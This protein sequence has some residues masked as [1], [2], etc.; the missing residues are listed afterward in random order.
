MTTKTERILK[1]LHVLAWI[2]FIGLFIKAGAILISYLISLENTEA[3]SNLYEGLNL[4]ELRENKVY[5]YSILLAFMIGILLLQAYITYI[6]IKILSKINLSNPFHSEVAL[7]IE[8]VSYLILI[9]WIVTVIANAHIQ[10]LQ[11]HTMTVGISS[12]SIDFI[13]LAGVIFVI[14]QIFKRGVEIQSEQEL[15]V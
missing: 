8:K 11:D 1:V 5:H 4:S 7:L 6:V 10:W 3:A 9:T 15:T 12:N 13:F 2:V 14:A